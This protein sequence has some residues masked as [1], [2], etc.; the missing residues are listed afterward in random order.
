MEDQ[1][2]EVKDENGMP[3][4]IKFTDLMAQIHGHM[5]ET[6][7]FMKEASFVTV[8]NG[9]GKDRIFNAGEWPQ[10]VYDRLTFKSWAPWIITGLTIIS[11]AL[12]IIT[13]LIKT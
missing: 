1:F 8:K 7:K 5:I 10:W 13:G 9:G 6:R 4:S 11:L 3:V 12:G 2:L